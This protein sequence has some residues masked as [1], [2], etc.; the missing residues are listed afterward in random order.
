MDHFIFV[1]WALLLSKAWIVY[2]F[3]AFPVH[4]YAISDHLSTQ[5][6]FSEELHRIKS[7]HA[8]PRANEAATSDP[9]TFP[10]VVLRILRRQAG[11]LLSN[12]G[13]GAEGP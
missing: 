13:G 4:A 11:G 5:Y 8:P 12:W 10:I 9:I 6:C 7:Y 2:C 3:I 1:N